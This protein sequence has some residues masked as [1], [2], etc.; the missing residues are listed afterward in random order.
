M[1]KTS[2]YSKSIGSAFWSDLQGISPL[3]IALLVGGCAATRERAESSTDQ[4]HAPI[5]CTLT[6]ADKAANARLSVPDFD[7]VASSPVT[8][9][10]LSSRGCYAAAARAGIDYLA[11]AKIDSERHQSSVIFHIAQNLAM[12]GSETSAAL[13]VAAAKRPSQ[14]AGAPFDWNTYVVGTWA[15]LSRNRELLQLSYDA[16]LAQAGEGN[17]T[18]AKVLGGLLHCYGQPYAKAYSPECAIAGSRATQA[19]T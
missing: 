6:E 9:R 18:N 17:Q 3:A 13:V 10:G 1:R 4:R 12:S 16:L 7:Y 2:L 19:A 5:D 8:P 14:A 15:F 11:R